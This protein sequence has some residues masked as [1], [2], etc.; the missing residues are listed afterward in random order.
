[1]GPRAHF[2]TTSTSARHGVKQKVQGGA[3]NYA[4]AHS[5]AIALTIVVVLVIGSEAPQAVSLIYRSATGQRTFFDYFESGMVTVSE[6]G[7]K[8]FLIYFTHDF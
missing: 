2:Q 4:A 5:P 7:H 8:V 1:M 3:P 6:S